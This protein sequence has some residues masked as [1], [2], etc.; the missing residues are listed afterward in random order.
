MATLADDLSKL[1]ELQR[2]VRSLPDE[3]FSGSGVDALQGKFVCFLWLLPARSHF[4]CVAS[5]RLTLFPPLHS[6]DEESIDEFCRTMTDARGT[7]DVFVRV[8]NEQAGRAQVLI[9]SLERLIAEEQQQADKS[10]AAL[11]VM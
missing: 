7:L 2:T 1:D 6:A 8:A 5:S 11:Q 4:F 9:R 10:V 3:V